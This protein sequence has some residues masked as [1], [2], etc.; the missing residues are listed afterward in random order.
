VQTSTRCCFSTGPVTYTTPNKRVW[1]L[2][3]SYH[4]PVLRASTTAV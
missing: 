2:R 4:L 1:K 3:T